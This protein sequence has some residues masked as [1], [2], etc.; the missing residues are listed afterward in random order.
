MHLITNSWPQCKHMQGQ[1][2]KWLNH[3]L[4][5]LESTLN[6][7]QTSALQ[8]YTS[9]VWNANDLTSDYLRVSFLYFFHSIFILGSTS[10]TLV[11]AQW[12][13]DLP[14]YHA[15]RHYCTSLPH[16][17]LGRARGRIQWGR[18]C[19]NAVACGKLGDLLFLLC[20]HRPLLA[21]R[22]S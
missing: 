8:L 18:E 9:A 2:V 20:S 3:N 16:C 1:R 5:L 14:T 15:L 22:G 13:G 12:K 6:L 7:T 10:Q 19:N 11:S 21:C 4:I 17:I